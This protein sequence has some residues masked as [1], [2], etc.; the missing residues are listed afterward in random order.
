MKIISKINFSDLKEVQHRVWKKKETS[1]KYN[2]FRDI[3]L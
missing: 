2:H 1:R 3:K